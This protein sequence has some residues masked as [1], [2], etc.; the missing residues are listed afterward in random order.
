MHII[1]NIYYIII[2]RDQTELINYEQLST[3]YYQY[4][5][6]VFP[7]LYRNAQRIFSMKC[8]IIIT[9]LVNI[10][11]VLNFST[12]FA[13]KFKVIKELDETKCK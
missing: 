4:F 11:Y 5:F 2:L 7:T 12:N 9:K 10:K 6:Q 13:W 1:Y 8:F 3:K